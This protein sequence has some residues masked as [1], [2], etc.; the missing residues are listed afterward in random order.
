MSIEAEMESLR[1]SWART[2]RRLS[3]RHGHK[4][5][6]SIVNGEDDEALED[7]SSWLHL[8]NRIE[9]RAWLGKT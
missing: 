7:L 9:R 3:G 6:V 4:R 1:E 5:A 2:F 8:G